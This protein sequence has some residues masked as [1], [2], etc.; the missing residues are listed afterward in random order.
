MTNYRMMKEYCR[1]NADYLVAGA[2]AVMAATGWYLTREVAPPKYVAVSSE[3]VGEL[4]QLVTTA[5]PGR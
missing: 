5:K 2:I 4:E 3:E 1:R